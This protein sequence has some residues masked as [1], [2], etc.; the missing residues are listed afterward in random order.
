[1]CRAIHRLTSGGR[2]SDPQAAQR[3]YGTGRGAVFPASK[4]GSLVHPLRRAL[5]SPKRTVAAMGLRGSERVLELGCGPGYFTPA[6][7][8]AVPRG[9]V[10]ALDLQSEMLHRLRARTGGASVAPTQG[11]ACALPFA[12][13]SFDAVLIATVL[14]EVPDPGRCL[15]EVRRV[16]GSGG[17][18]TIAETRRDADFTPLADLQAL[19]HRQGLDFIGRRGVRWQYVARFRARAAF[20]G[21]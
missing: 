1:M 13:G 16:L 9:T 18:A 8:A 6:L 7:V 20:R 14:G 3:T 2:V 4:A 5:Q 12:G 21:G 19:A 17:T 15:A 10:V 11:D